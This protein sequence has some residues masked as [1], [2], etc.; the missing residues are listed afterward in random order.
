[1]ITTII[2]LLIALNL[3]SQPADWEQLSSEEQQELANQVVD[4]DLIAF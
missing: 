4:S 1:M 3:L 2:T